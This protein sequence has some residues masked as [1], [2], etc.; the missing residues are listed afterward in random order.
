MASSA[1]DQKLSGSMDVLV[2]QAASKVRRS[3]NIT[4]LGLRPQISLIQIAHGMCT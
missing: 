2:E 4:G 3:E 1:L